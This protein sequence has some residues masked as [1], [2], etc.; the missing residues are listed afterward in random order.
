MMNYIYPE[1]QNHESVLKYPDVKG[2]A[3]NLFFFNHQWK[4]ENNQF[5]MSKFNVKEAE[6]VVRFALYLL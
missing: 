4:E 2:V 6:M 5:M 3:K 1:L